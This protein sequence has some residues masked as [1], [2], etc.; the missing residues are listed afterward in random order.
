[1]NKSEYLFD[2][3]FTTEKPK[4]G[5]D[6]KYEQTLVQKWKKFNEKIIK[7]LQFFVQMFVFFV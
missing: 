6:K 7:H 2:L 5:I 1:M 3:L 4:N